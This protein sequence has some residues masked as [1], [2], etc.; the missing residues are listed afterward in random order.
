MF[1][2]IA[3]G[4]AYLIVKVLDKKSEYKTPKGKHKN[5]YK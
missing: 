4:A 2:I 1:G 5:R 3:L